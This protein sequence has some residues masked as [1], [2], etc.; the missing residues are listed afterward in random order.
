M[1]A[2][3][4]RRAI[5]P[6]Y[7]SVLRGRETL[8][9]LNQ[10]ERT[11][12]QRPEDVRAMQLRK[13][14]ET[15]VHCGENVPY[16]RRM[17]RDLGF[18]P[19]EVSGLDDIGQLPILTRD[20][21]RE[22]QQD[23]LDER[24]E[25]DSLVSYGTGGS[26]GSPLQFKISRD[27]YE[28]RMAGQYRGYRW[29]GWD[30]GKKT[31]WFWGVSGS[32]NPRPSGWRKRFKKWLNNVIW[33]HK[34]R[35]LYQFSDESLD[36][37][38]QFWS[39][40]GPQSVAG[41]A[42]GMYCIARHVLDNG[43]SVPKCDGV[44]LAAEATTERQREAMRRAFGCEVF[45]TYGSM[46]F[47][48]IAGECDAHQGMHIN[49]DN[50]LVEITQDGHPLPPG[51]EGEI[52]VT[53]LVHPAMPFVRYTIGDRG[54]LAGEPCPC[55]RGFPLLKSVAGRTMDMVRTPEG[56]NVSGV[57]FNHTMLVVS[58]VKRFQ[59]HQADESAITMRIV[60]NDGYGP[61]VEE[62][63]EKALRNAL[64]HGIAINFEVVDEVEFSNSGKYRVIVSDVGYG[65][66]DEERTADLTGGSP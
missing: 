1:Y 12:W 14:R 54:V 53:S 49:C 31:L 4:F 55:G 66:A 61:E 30:L 10:Y 57:W 46:E 18:D 25:P 45:N 13:L 34:I 58:E 29:A 23:L 65:H 44:I 48:M 32:I 47:N 2:A 37:Y 7:E 64:G 36:D 27:F 33:R 3:L 56:N 41:Y 22:N 6:L 39:D 60:P 63:I 59:V 24:L 26:T 40:W 50:L 19:S 20:D 38:V 5:L 15:L 21:I 43:L 8:E 11:Q 51:E 42:F 17:F 9:Y 16:Y 62:R 35:T 52:T 28:R